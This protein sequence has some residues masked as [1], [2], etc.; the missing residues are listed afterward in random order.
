LL[1]APFKAGQLFLQRIHA[2]QQF[3][4]LAGRTSKDLLKK[5]SLCLCPIALVGG[6]LNLSQQVVPIHRELLMRLGEFSVLLLKLTPLGVRRGP[7]GFNNGL[8]AMA[9]AEL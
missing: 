7:L 4:A 3:Q 9:L 1:E 8:L 2:I 5:L 6:P